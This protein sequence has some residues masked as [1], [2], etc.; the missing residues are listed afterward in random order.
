MENRLDFTWN[1]SCYVDST[2]LLLTNLSSLLS[3]SRIL[4]W[5]LFIISLTDWLLLVFTRIILSFRLFCDKNPTAT[6]STQRVL[7]LFIN[8]QSHAVPN[9]RYA[10]LK[11][12]IK[13]SYFS[14]Y[15][16]CVIYYSH[17]LSTFI[18]KSTCSNRQ[19]T[20]T[21]RARLLY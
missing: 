20:T 2:C 5:F 10:V 9:H 16:M 6:K 13:I 18:E 8:E 1:D 21:S 7:I 12:R 11:A 14:L 19:H 4:Y 15:F 17:C 3:F